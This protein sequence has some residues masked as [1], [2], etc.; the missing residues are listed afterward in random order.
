MQ[1]LTFA[2]IIDG[3]RER[4]KMIVHRVFSLRLPQPRLGD[5][6]RE[7]LGDNVDEGARIRYK[8]QRYGVALYMIKL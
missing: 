2:A 3:A 7:I 4:A 6:A 1:H 8:L 5:F